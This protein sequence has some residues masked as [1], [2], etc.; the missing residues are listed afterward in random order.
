MLSVAGKTRIFAYTQPADLRKSYDGLGALVR[1]HLTHDLLEGDLFVFVNRTRSRLKA[2]YFDGTGV[3]ILQK[4]L[5]VGRFPCLWDKPMPLVLTPA[6]M[7]LLLDGHHVVGR[8]DLK[9]APIA[10]SR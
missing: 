1:D 10:F 6:E 7:A 5:E 9:P 2:L 3:C 4:R 8:L